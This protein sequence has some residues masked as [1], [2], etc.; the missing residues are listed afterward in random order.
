MAMQVVL[1]EPKDI[2]GSDTISIKATELMYSLSNDIKTDPVS[3][4]KEVQQ[5][6]VNG[7]TVQIDITGIISGSG[8]AADLAALLVAAKEWWWY[9]A[10][11]VNG[12]LTDKT[13]FPKIAWRGKNY[14]MLIASF[15]VTDLA[16]TDGNEFEY[17]MSIGID[18][19]TVV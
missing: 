1:T 9:P 8:A 6:Q 18:T 12:D 14:Y 11:P 16:E 17:S 3:L 19:R 10:N 15:D 2:G 5:M 7:G 13:N 4:A